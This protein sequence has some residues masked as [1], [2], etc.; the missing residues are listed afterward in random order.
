MVKL[1]KSS[2]G[3]IISI[4]L[5]NQETKGDTSKGEAGGDDT[6]GTKARHADTIGDR[7]K[8]ETGGHNR[9]QIKK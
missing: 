2:Q 7:I 3:M 1:E 5:R 9:R 6:T 8:K 4:S